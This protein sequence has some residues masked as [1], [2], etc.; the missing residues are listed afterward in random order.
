ML[1]G[2]VRYVVCGVAG[3]FSRSVCISCFFVAAAAFVAL[4]VA[5]C[6]PFKTGMSL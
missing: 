1:F 2:F 3:E 4:E 6:T 5:Y